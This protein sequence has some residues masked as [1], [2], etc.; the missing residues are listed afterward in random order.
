MLN[1]SLNVKTGDGIEG[2]VGILKLHH[3]AFFANHTRFLGG[4]KLRS[5]HLDT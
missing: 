1:D 2:E 5:A 4:L 3:F